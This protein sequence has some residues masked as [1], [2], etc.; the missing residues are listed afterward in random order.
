LPQEAQ[1]LKNEQKS[2]FELFVLFYGKSLLRQEGSQF[3]DDYLLADAAERAVE[4]SHAAVEFRAVGTA[5][6]IIAT[7]EEPDCPLRH[8]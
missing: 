1:K 6:K 3:P 5:M 8:G 7:L 2:I 4:V